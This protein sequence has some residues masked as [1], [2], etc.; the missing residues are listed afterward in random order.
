M[1]PMFSWTRLFEAV[2]KGPM[3]RLQSV[4]PTGQSLPA[5]S[6]C[7]R[8]RGILVVLCLHAVGFALFGL[9]SRQDLTHCLSEAGLLVAIAMLAGLPSLHPRIRAAVASGGLITASALLVHVSGGYKHPPRSS[10]RNYALAS[11][12]AARIAALYAEYFVTGC[13]FCSPWG[14][15]LHHGIV[16]VL[17][18]HDV[19]NHTSGVRASLAVGGDSWCICPGGEHCERGELA[20][21]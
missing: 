18:P 9:M 5:E 7:S 13:R 16:G 15:I 2:C 3:R 6:W 20:S 21:A 8:H 4:I 19:Y 11:Q 1:A 10:R 12:R 17:F 14:V